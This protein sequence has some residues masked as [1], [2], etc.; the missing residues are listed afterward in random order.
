MRKSGRAVVA[1]GSLSYKPN[2]EVGLLREVTIDVEGER[3]SRC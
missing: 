3:G 2:G 1:Y